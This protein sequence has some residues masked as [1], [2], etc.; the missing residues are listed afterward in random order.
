[1]QAL[2]ALV[3]AILATQHAVG[4]VVKAA[5]GE[6][7]NMT[8][9][10]VLA[11]RLRRRQQATFGLRRKTEEWK[12]RAQIDGPW[13]KVP[14]T[15]SYGK[16]LCAQ[17][18]RL[19]PQVYLLGAAK[20]AT[21]SLAANLMGAGV[22]T[23]GPDCR[24]F[25]YPYEPQVVNTAK[26]MHFFDYNMSWASPDEAEVR[27]NWLG[28][29]PECTR[30]FMAVTKHQKRRLIGDFTPEHLRMVPLPEG[31][32]Y[33]ENSMVHS[34]YGAE[35]GGAARNMLYMPSLL[36]NLYGPSAAKR[37]T[38]V[39]MLREPLARMQSLYYCCICYTDGVGRLPDECV[40]T[41]FEKD[42][43]KDL[44][45]LQQT[46]PTY[47]DWI[48]GGYYGR[49]LEHWMTKFEA[50]QFYI[51]PF[52]VFT[53][54]DGESICRD[55]AERLEFAMGCDSSGKQA[56]WMEHDRPHPAL[57]QDVSD[58]TSWA[59]SQLMALENWRLARTL[60]KGQTEGL[61]LAGY[62]GQRGDAEEV[63]SWLD[64]S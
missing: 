34:L 64:N 3:T 52:R 20:S 33:S 32:I 12:A 46:P 50:S 25:C 13:A 53:E 21:T 4:G 30:G 1:M 47:S 57:S 10:K 9:Q 5:E 42:L 14:Q 61:G 56:T 29:L 18:G 19:L 38:F 27:K 22:E 39:V 63:K 37:V 45:L 36:Y 8:G 43:R 54:G 40:G 35:P 31:A 17:E 7:H 24:G 44:S 16:N 62:H 58:D 49:H 23:P 15:E 26:E 6:I 2:L 55:L 51:V 28:L 60:A 41:N 11:F 59:Y 48:W